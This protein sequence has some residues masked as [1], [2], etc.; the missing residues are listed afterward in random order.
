MIVVCIIANYIRTKLILF[1]GGHVSD[2]F[3]IAL[4]KRVFQ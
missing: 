4:E 2:S 1:N 3:N